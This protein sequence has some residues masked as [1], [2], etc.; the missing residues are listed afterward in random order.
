MVRM[1]EAFA[2]LG[3]EV[4]LV[5]S[6]QGVSA[7]EILDFYGVEVEI[8][9][10]RVKVSKGKIGNMSYAIKAGLAA[11]RAA[12]DYVVGRSVSA[13]AFA[14]FL[15]CK[16][17]LDSHGPVWQSNI[18]D[19]LL[20]RYMVM[21]PSLVRM[22]VNS[23]ALKKMYE[24][25]GAVPKCGITVA[26]NG[27]KPDAGIVEIQQWPGRA[28]GQQIGY[29]GNLYP[30]RGIDLIMECAKNM[31]DSDFHIFGG[32]EK[33]IDFWRNNNLPS[34]VF[35]H[36]FINNHLVQS[37]RARCD[38]LLAPYQ[39][40]GVAVAGGGGDSSRYMNPIK[41]VEYMSSGKAIVC[42][43][44]IV[45]REVL[46]DDGAVFVEPDNIQEWISAIGLLKDDK[47]RD[48][49]SRRAL[50]RFNC[51]LTWHSRARNVLGII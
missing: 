29:F 28:G 35:L 19:W 20:F 9:I 6:E 30:G 25:K 8:N 31:P 12:P 47:V 51:G 3:H 14:C 43:D 32:S 21:C 27:S 45:L 37:Y 2:E 5:V 34:N 24:E 1:C 33:D 16:T 38:V 44:I 22:T 49:Y 42:S 13:C 11:R 41:I 50:D 18:F 23:N 4:T 10:I 48:E 15:R 39:A 26:F 17:V 46:G 36:G 40:S 7:R